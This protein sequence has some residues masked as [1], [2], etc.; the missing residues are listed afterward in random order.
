MNFFEYIDFDI[1]PQREEANRIKDEIT[2]S[3]LPEKVKNRL[4]ESLS[5]YEDLL[6]EKEK[7]SNTITR[8]IKLKKQIEGFE[9]LKN[10]IL[11][12]NIKDAFTKIQQSKAEKEFPF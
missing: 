9:W 1:E 3:L 8:E 6:E 2:S 5:S 4:I 7:H 12:D 10:L 11:T